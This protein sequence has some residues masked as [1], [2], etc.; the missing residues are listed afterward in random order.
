[1]H[2]SLTPRTACVRLTPSSAA[3]PD[4]GRLLLQAAPGDVAEVGAAGALE[5]VSGERRHV[6]QLRARREDEALSDDG[7]LF[8]DQRIARDIRHAGKRAEPQAVANRLDAIEACNAR[9]VDEGAG[10]HRVKLHE[11]QDR[12][13]TGKDL[14]RGRCRRARRA[15]EQSR[16]VVE[17]F[18]AEIGERLHH[19]LR[20]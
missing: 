13:P 8:L 2:A 6:A 10:L 11:V 16:G 1:M 17:A 14:R 12:R 3:Q 7:V 19:A 15:A 18:G 4:P 5:R 20:I 9:D